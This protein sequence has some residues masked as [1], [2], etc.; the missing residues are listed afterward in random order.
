L[1]SFWDTILKLIPATASAVASG[2]AA[3]TAFMAYRTNLRASVENL[4]PEIK[5]GDWGPFGMGSD[6]SEI[7]NCNL[8]ENTGKGRAENITFHVECDRCAVEFSQHPGFSLFPGENVKYANFFNVTRPDQLEVNPKSLLPGK[9]RLIFRYNDVH[10]S[11]HTTI[12]TI[13]VEAKRT[14]QGENH[15]NSERMP[16]GFFFIGKETTTKLHLDKQFESWKFR[17]TAFVKFMKTEINP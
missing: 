12:Y 14:I 10:K 5:I 17:W 9:M 16:A 11:T 3:F 2:A 7:L 15:L 4:R 6:G 1:D 8:I 13:G